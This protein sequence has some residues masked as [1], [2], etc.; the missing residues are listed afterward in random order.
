[1]EIKKLRFLFFLVLS[2]LANNL[3][4]NEVSIQERF[5]SPSNSETVESFFKNLFRE[6]SAGY[7]V[8]GEKPIYLGSSCHPEWLMPGSSRHKNA[9][10]YFLSLI[11]LQDRNKETDPSNYVTISHGIHS[12]SSRNTEFMLINRKAFCKVVEDNLVLFKYKFG[13][14]ITPESLLDK[15]TSPSQSFSELFGQEP[16]LAGIVLGYGT[17]NAISY[18]RASLFTDDIDSN[19]PSFPPNMISPPP[20]TEEE[21]INRIESTTKKKNLWKEVKE[22]TKDI[23]YYC[24]RNSNDKLKIPFGFHKDSKE[25]QELFK[26]YRKA[27]AQ[28]SKALASKNFLKQILRALQISPQTI[29]TQSENDIVKLSIPERKDLSKA[30][31]RSIKWTFSE[32]ISP[33]FIEGMRAAQDTNKHKNTVDFQDIEFLEIL[34]EQGFSSNNRK[35]SN[36]DSELFFQKI[37]DDPNTQC[38]VPNKLYIRT[39][40]E[41]SSEK[42]IGL[43]C[44]SIKANYLIRDVNGKP[45]S[46]VYK[47]DQPSKFN[48]ENLIPGLAHGVVGMKEGDIREIYIHPDFAYGTYSEF[49]SGKALQ[50]QIEL[51]DI[52]NASDIIKMPQLRPPDVVFFTPEIDNCERFKALQK[53]YNYFCGMETW[54]HYKKAK[55]LVDFNVVLEEISSENS[56]SVS[57]K[58][59][60]MISKLNWIIYQN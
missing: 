42:S 44:K 9:V 45:I 3:T 54:L 18:E 46:G 58:E 57:E 38:L 14:D 55:P 41:G 5:H 51:I 49:G 24:P 29:S 52:E 15:L 53:K 48:L 23:S 32:Q 25:T 8:F 6:T 50:V 19:T 59:R 47:G 39:L 31:A 4:S 27:E 30:L 33:E 21:M 60:V 20:K 36:R 17:N 37:A 40:R 43:S 26:K 34:R 11:I 35:K 1:M 16:A 22:E 7:V 10:T 2:F 12:P 28:L 13:H 56:L